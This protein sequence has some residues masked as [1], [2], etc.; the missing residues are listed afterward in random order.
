MAS[1]RSRRAG[2]MAGDVGGVGGDL[3]GDDAVLHILLVGQAEVL[4]G[5]DVAE[6]RR[7]VPADHRRADGR[8]DVVV[9]GSDV[10]DQR[11]ERVERRAVA[12]FDF[13]VDLLLDLVERHVAGTFDHDLHVVLPGLRGQ[14]AE[15]L[16]LGELRLVAGVGDAAGAEAVAEREADVVLRH[17]LHDAVEVLVEEVLLVV[18]GH[19]LRQDGAAAADDAGDALRDHGHVL[20]EHAGVDGEVVDA[21]LG[22]LLDDLEVEVDVEV[23]EPS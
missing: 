20:D 7:A 2:A 9:A 22:L 18:V 21:L 3:V 5:R 1:S 23:F 14:L 6:H 11:A 15:R 16:E 4:L 10:G 8:G 17:D 13:L 19:P 12:V